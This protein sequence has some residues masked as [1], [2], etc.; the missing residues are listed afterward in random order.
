MNDPLVWR[1]SYPDGRVVN[2]SPVDG[3]IRVAPRGACRLDLF[4]PAGRGVVGVNLD[5]AAGDV[6]IFYRKRSASP[7][8]AGTSRVDATVFG[9]AREHGSVID[10]N[11]WAGI[12][13]QIVD[14]PAWA[15]DHTM[16]EV[17]TT[18]ERG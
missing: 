6:P 7:G 8:D 14:C 13:G 10:S 12:D 9:R 16:I 2:E 3:S 11:L 5:P 4:T 18:W 1:L 15:I 17:L